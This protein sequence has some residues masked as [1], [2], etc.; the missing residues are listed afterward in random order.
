M[1]KSKQFLFLLIFE[2]NS[3]FKNFLGFFKKI[4]KESTLCISN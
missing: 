3:F 1:I 2:K 4:I